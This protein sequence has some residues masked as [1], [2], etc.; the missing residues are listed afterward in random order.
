MATKLTRLTH[1]IA[2]QLLL[3]AENCTLCS[4]RSRLSVQKLLDTPS[5]KLL[6]VYSTRQ[7]F[8]NG[9][10]SYLSAAVNM[11]GCLRNPPSVYHLDQTTVKNCTTLLHTHFSNA[12]FAILHTLFSL[13]PFITETNIQYLRVYK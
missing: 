2:M 7:I 1:K 12:L 9:V 13:C 5:Y 3:V 4:F 11:F 6:V 8:N 10:G